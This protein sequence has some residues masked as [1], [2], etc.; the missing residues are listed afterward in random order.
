MAST[1]P[2]EDGRVAASRMF[3][4]LT[5]SATAAHRNG[6][7]GAAT[8]GQSLAR[9]QILDTLSDQRLTMPQI[10]RQVRQ[11]RQ[12]IKRVV[13]L[14]EAE[15]LIERF[16]NH[17]HRRSPLFTITGEGDRMLGLLAASVSDWYAFV[18]ERMPAEEIRALTDQ[19]AHLRTIADEYHQLAASD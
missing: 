8:V 15:G 19:L 13:D 3:R 17:G 5:F 2:P 7:L 6:E 1:T 10:A 18:L 12:S 9:W 4:E 11:S 14:L 16:D